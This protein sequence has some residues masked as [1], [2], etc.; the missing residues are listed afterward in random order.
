MNNILIGN[1]IREAREKKRLTQEKLAELTKLST[2]ALSNIE[3]GKACPNFKNI[4]SLATTLEISIDF[5]IAEEQ[6]ELNKLYIH[7]INVMLHNMD[8]WK[9]VHINKYIQL[10]NET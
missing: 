4:V 9:L 7:E 3:S 10:L 1:R 5:L 8:E 6:T 2:T